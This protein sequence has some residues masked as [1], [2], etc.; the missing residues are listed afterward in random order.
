MP[1]S[2]PYTIE[3]RILAAVWYHES[4]QSIAAVKSIKHKLRERFDDEP[5]HSRVIQTWAEK[6]FTNGTVLDKSRSGR[7]NERGDSED[8]VD[9]HVRNNPTTGT[10]R[11]SDELDI[12]RTTMMRIMKEDLKYKSFKPVKVQ[13]LSPDDQISRVHCCQQILEKYDNVRR[14][15]D[16]FFSDE[17]AIYAEGKG[18]LQI[19][20]WSKA[21]PHFHEQI[22]Q[23]PPKVMV[24]AAMSARH[25]IGPFFINGTVN[26][27]SYVNLLRDDFIPAL[28]QRGILQ[29]SHFQQD[30]APAHTAALTRNFLDENFPNR[31]VGKYGPTPWP[32]RSP[33]IT[34]CDNALWGLLKP[35]IIRHKVGTVQ[36]LKDVIHQEF[37]NFPLNRLEAINDRTFRRMHLCVEKQGLQVE[38]YDK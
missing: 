12:P 20:F 28:Q 5:P 38:P 7:P 14:R 27:Q 30:G 37:A 2:S 29:R 22:K 4:D 21:N 13:Y 33:D 16:L 19:S 1:D 8:G 36:D 9:T 11:R 10:R 3:Y 31:W 6:L 35:N 15:Q 25:L 23:H 18:S 17:C 34:S 24:W 32:A 26:A